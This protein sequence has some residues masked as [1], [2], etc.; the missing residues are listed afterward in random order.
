MPP[1]STPGVPKLLAIA[2]VAAVSGVGAT[3][4]TGNAVKPCAAGFVHAIIAG[5]HECLRAGQRC[6]RRSDKQYH[7]YGFHC[8]GRRLSVDPWHPLRRPLKIPRIAPGSACPTSAEDT[9]VDFASFGVSP[10]IGDGPVYPTG[11]VKPS[12]P[13]TLQFQYPPRRGSV[14]FGSRWGGERILWFVLPTYTGRVLVRGRRV[15]GREELRFQGGLVPP[16]ELKL[17]AVPGGDRQVAAYTRLRTPGCWGYQVD[18]RGFSK[19]IVF[20]AR[21]L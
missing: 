4:S 2:V 17:A 10:G 6:D 11:L 21:L 14:F 5:K 1:G 12:G 8:H 19:V 7:R 16:R 15:D 13:P 9:S 3:A 18:S 20:Q